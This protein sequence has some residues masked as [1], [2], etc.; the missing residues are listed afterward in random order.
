MEKGGICGRTTVYQSHFLLLLGTQPNYTSHLSL[1][2]IGITDQVLANRMRAEVR[3]PILGLA[4]KKNSHFLFSHVL[5]K[6]RGFGEN[7]KMEEAWVPESLYGAERLL[8]PPQDCDLSSLVFH[9]AKLL[10]SWGCL[11]QQLAPP[12]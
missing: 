11:L 3:M 6:W 8:Q 2:L 1:Q 10:R 12:L 7:H 4:H 5:A 9:S